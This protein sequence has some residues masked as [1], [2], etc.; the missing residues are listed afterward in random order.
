M[1]IWIAI[2]L[3]AVSL[4]AT[5]QT[6]TLDNLRQTYIAMTAEIQR[7]QAERSAVLREAR[8]AEREAQR[9]E[10]LRQLDNGM[11]RPRLIQMRP[12]TPAEQTSAIDARI[13]AIAR[14]R[15][16]VMRA[17]RQLVAAN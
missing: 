7:L 5:A 6:V 13:A 12:A 17:M 4:G 16:T 10:R 3:L 14:H 15:Q 11:S 9:K 1:R 2:A 8:E